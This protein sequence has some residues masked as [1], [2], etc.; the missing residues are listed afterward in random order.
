[1]AA[2][3]VTAL[4]LIVGGGVVGYRWLDRTSAGT[5]GRNRTPG[6]S[7]SSA[8][9]AA[10][11]YRTDR[12]PEQPCDKVDIGPL[13]GI[14]EEQVST[15]TQQKYLSTV[16]NTFTCSH[17]RQ[18]VKGGIPAVSAIVTF[19]GSLYGDNGLADNHHKTAQ[20]NAK[21]NG[22]PAAL[23]GIGGEA[24]IYRSK[25]VSDEARIAD[26]VIDVRDGNLVWQAR[27]I[28]TQVSGAWSD[29]DLARLQ[30]LLIASAKV[31]YAKLTAG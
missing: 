8:S 1:V 30:S 27:V 2:A 22:N 29:Q 14:F 25:G 10:L 28:A 18:H 20:A 5:G 26:L 9:G 7:A 4:L 24:I 23:D 11:K 13:A 6:S 21:L 3:A 31:S 17:V 15:P 19:Y 16:V 12:I